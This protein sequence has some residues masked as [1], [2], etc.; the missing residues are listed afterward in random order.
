MSNV[1]PSY[2]IFEPAVPDVEPQQIELDPVVLESDMYELLQTL[3]KVAMASGE[4]VNIDIAKNELIDIIGPCDELVLDEICPERLLQA[5]VWRANC[6][7]MGEFYSVGA[8]HVIV[9]EGQDKL[10]VT[11]CDYLADE[12]IETMHQLNADPYYKC[13]PYEIVTGTVEHQSEFAEA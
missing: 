2:R 12:F 13:L 11:E 4:P 8:G 6:Y 7:A 1:H 5:V 9:T 10:Y 3:K